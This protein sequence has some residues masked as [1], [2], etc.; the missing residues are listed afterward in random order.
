MNKQKALILWAIIVLFPLPLWACIFVID[1]Y[2]GSAIFCSYYLPLSCLGEPWFRYSGDI[3]CFY[4]TEYGLM[5]T[6]VIYSTIY[7]MC[8]V[9]W[10][11]VKSHL[12]SKHHAARRKTKAPAT[13]PE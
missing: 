7:W 2:T 11:R 3:G 9:L 6:P 1:I 13:G 12:D 8:V 5:L 4:P 10:W